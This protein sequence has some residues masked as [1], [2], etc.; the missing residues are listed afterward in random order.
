M[1]RMGFDS[2]ENFDD[3]Q[4][5][6]GSVESQ[7]E[8]FMLIPAV[9]ITAEA[10]AFSGVQTAD[11]VESV[12]ILGMTF[13]DNMK[14]LLVKHTTTNNPPSLSVIYFI[15]GKFATGTIVRNYE[16]GSWIPVIVD[17]T[18]NH[19]GYFIFKLCP[20]NDITQD[21]SQP[22]FDQHVLEVERD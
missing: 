19:G 22:C 16:P 18:T 4:T 7:S 17:I 21:P 2:P 9:I 8:G 5:Y 6:C 13:Q 11:V 3:D 15:L 1:W 14:H 20:N 12:E 10:G